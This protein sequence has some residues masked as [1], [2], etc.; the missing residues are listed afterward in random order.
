MSKKRLYNSEIKAILN[1]KIK[2]TIKESSVAWPT[3]RIKSVEKIITERV[4]NELKDKI[5]YGSLKICFDKG[6]DTQ[7]ALENMLNQY[8]TDKEK[9]LDEIEQY[10]LGLFKTKNY[11]SNIHLRINV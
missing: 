9:F 11:P 8:E 5:H 3:E 10:I 4:E 7:K 6:I 1:S 2:I